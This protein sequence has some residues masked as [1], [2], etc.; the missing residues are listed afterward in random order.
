[1]EDIRV[2]GGAGPRE[3]VSSRWRPHTSCPSLG[4]DLGSLFLDGGAETSQGSPAI[5]LPA[6]PPARLPAGSVGAGSFA[7]DTQPRGSPAAFPCS[8]ACV[9]VSRGSSR[10]AGLFG[11]PAPP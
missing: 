11:G 8:T 10:T 4:L 3:E 9:R 2:S 5:P 1:M 6:R 7:E